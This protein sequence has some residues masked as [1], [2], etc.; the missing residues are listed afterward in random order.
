[1]GNCSEH[2]NGGSIAIVRIW[3]VGIAKGMIEALEKFANEV[4]LPMFRQ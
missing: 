3:K 4:S 2:G 1:M